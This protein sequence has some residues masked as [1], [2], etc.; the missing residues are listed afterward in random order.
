[1]MIG[2][3]FISLIYATISTGNETEVNSATNDMQ[4][5]T[6]TPTPLPKRNRSSGKRGGKPVTSAHNSDKCHG[7]MCPKDEM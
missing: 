5:P 7:S 2:I 3:L 1:M 6:S 4:S